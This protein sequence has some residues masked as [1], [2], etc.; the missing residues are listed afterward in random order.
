MNSR[1]ASI[2]YNLPPILPDQRTYCIIGQGRGGTG[3]AANLVDI[4]GIPLIRH[5]SN[6]T[7]DREFRTPVLKFHQASLNE[8][9]EIKEEIKKEISK[10]NI[11]PVWA[12]KI[13][14]CGKHLLLWYKLIRNPFWIYIIRDH[15]AS[16]LTELRI[17]VINNVID[18]L[19]IKCENELYFQEFICKVYE[20]KQ[21]IYLISYERARIFKGQFIEDLCK[22]LGTNPSIKNVTDAV[23]YIRNTGPLQRS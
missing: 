18:G 3:M 7:E 16:A 21:P 2:I 6:D 23:D 1:L 13:P 19:R 10:R 4:L 14:Q 17:N 20:E 15:M 5:G 22:F 11:N 9:E 8:Y 12:W